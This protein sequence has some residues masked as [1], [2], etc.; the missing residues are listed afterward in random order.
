LFFVEPLNSIALLSKIVYFCRRGGGGSCFVVNVSCGYIVAI[1]ASGLQMGG[2]AESI[3]ALTSQRTNL[4]PFTKGCRERGVSMR[5]SDF[6]SDLLGPPFV[7]FF[8]GAKPGRKCV[9]SFLKSG[10]GDYHIFSC[11]MFCDIFRVEREE[12]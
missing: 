10:K 5:V 1:V 3:A 11:L 12:L 9:I 6:F 4:S 7:W 8:L 2:T